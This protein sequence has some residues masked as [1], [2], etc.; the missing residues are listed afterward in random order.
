MKNALY[1]G[2]NLE[3]MRNPKY[4]RDESV[5]FCY[6][7]PPFNSKRNYNQIYNNQG[8][9][10]IAQAQAFIDIH[11]WDEHAIKCYDEIRTNEG[12]RYTEQ[13]IELVKGLTEVLGKGPL[14]AYIVSMTARIVEIHR[15]LKSTGSFYLHCDP[16]SSHY[17]KLIIDSVFLPAGGDFRNEIIWRRSASHNSAKRFGPIH[18]VIFFYTKSAEYTWNQQYQP[19]IDEYKA[20]FKRIDEKTGLPFQDVNLTGPGVRTGPSGQPWGGLD[21]TSIGRHWQPASYVYKKYKELTGEELAQYP[22]LKRLDKLDEVGL[23]FWPKKKGGRPRYKQFLADA[24]GVPFQDVWTD[25]DAIN[26]QAKERIGYPTQKPV[27]LLERIIKSSTNEGD[28]ILDAYCGCGTTIAAAQKWNR[29][30][31][32]MDITAQAMSTIYIRLEDE[33]PDLDLRN[34]VEGGAPRDLKAARLLAHKR[35]DRLRKEFEKWAILTYCN[36]KA[37]IHEKKGGDKGIDG[38]HLHPGQ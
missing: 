33:F 3:L 24:A 17:L 2:D 38:Y 37:V 1:Y 19:Y 6:I 16:T 30:W 31:I 29:H 14:L 10:D 5:D 22:L 23:I 8:Y 36:H 27:A 25:I 35:D 28:V 9:E 12:N 32:G 4:V 21:P 11:T 7:D 13:T 26:S 18:D 20:R 15:L 34:I